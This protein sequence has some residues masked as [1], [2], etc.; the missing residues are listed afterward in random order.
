MKF[1]IIPAIIASAAALLAVS[2]GHKP[3]SPDSVAPTPFAIEPDY[4]G[5]TF[6]VNIAAPTFRINAPEGTV[7]Y[8]TEIGRC[9]NEPSI[10]IR[11]ADSAVETPLK[12]WQKLLEQCAGD[13]IYIRF[14]ALQPDGKWIGSPAI[15]CPVSANPIDRYLVYRLLYPG[16]ELWSEIGIY[17]RDLS[18]YEQTP[19]LE[20]KD[21]DIQCIN[22]HN[23]SANDPKRGM[24]V[25]VR[26]PQGGTLVSKNGEVEKVS[27]RMQGL[28][29]GATYPSWSRDGRHIAFSANNVMQV[30]HTA[31]SKPIEVVDL[32]ADLMVYDSE[33][34]QAF[35]DSIISGNH[36]LETFPTWT[37]QGDRIYFCRGPEVTETTALDTI[38]YDLYSIDFDSTT[39]RFS[40]LRPV[41]V[42]SADSASV[43]FP[44]VSPDGR[45]LMFTR[46]SYGNFSIW[47]P[48]SQLC[49]MN[50]ADGTWRELS[51]VNSPGVESY[52][53]W[54]STGNWFVFSSKRMDGLWARPFIA[55]FDPQ[56]GM[57]GKPFPVP[58][59]SADFYRLFTKTFNIPEF[60]TGPVE[61]PD[62]LFHGIVDQ[63]AQPVTLIKN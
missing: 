9:G 43:S 37:P 6:P 29:H 53:S 18:T 51:E 28:D 13:S 16:Y 41:Y 45:W 32:G 56:T 20:N 33:T 23:F 62:A 4:A 48:E 26:G 60:I 11:S 57:A 14:S 8:Q 17:Q 38:R 52:H 58:Q 3:I 27:S 63:K 49:L 15:V 5:A 12:K 61:N 31:G 55:A 34:H 24:M 42:A 40:N 2:C 44:R 47:H 10:I 35:T 7:E 25:H 46:S 21:F 39:G 54:S 59:K 36:H 22:C 1:P 19:I 30:F 50:L